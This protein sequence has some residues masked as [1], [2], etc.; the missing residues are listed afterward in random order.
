MIDVD[1]GQCETEAGS[2]ARQQL[3]QNHRVGA[4]GQADAEC[5]AGGVEIS[6]DACR[7]GERVT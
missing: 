7:L 3:E 4:A 2:K 5:A 1:R 6:E